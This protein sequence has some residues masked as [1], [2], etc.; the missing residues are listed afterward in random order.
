M[1]QTGVSFWIDL[2]PGVVGSVTNF[3]D[4]STTNSKTIVG[5]IAGRDYTFKITE[6]STGTVSDIVT[7]TTGF[8]RE[9]P[10]APTNVT[11]MPGNESVLIKYRAPDPYGTQNPLTGFKVEATSTSSPTTIS[12]NIPHPPVNS[13]ISYTDASGNLCYIVLNLVNSRAYTFKLYSISSAQS[14]STSNNTT[15]IPG[16][17]LAPP[18]PPAPTTITATPD[19]IVPGRVKVSWGSQTNVTSYKISCI[20][21][22][23]TASTPGIIRDANGYLS[24]DIRDINITTP[25][26]QELSFNFLK[27]D[28]FYIITLIANY[29]FPGS[30]T[31]TFSAPAQTQITTSTNGNGAPGEPSNVG[32]SLTRF[33]IN[34]NIR[35]HF[36][37]P[38]YNFNRN[39]LMCNAFAVSNPNFHQIHNYGLSQPY[40]GN[41]NGTA[42]TTTMKAIDNV[43]Y[44]G[45]TRVIDGENRFIVTDG[46]NTGKNR[47]VGF[48]QTGYTVEIELWAVL[49]ILTSRI[50]LVIFTKT[51]KVIKHQYWI[52]IPRDSEFDG[53]IDRGT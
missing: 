49:A 36:D 19:P 40:D 21:E 25:G 17:P 10:L 29:S 7:Y 5:L 30:Y 53:P 8:L 20:S 43:I 32:Y 37:I 28:T 50:C 14:T 26:P 41:T 12:Y 44:N 24:S 16:T 46:I 6:Q 38:L 22:S 18:S 1:D 15:T 48:P 52:T 42:L 51:D 33:G 31:T 2:V 13:A 9:N 3:R 45:F 27:L 23:I 34:Y 39:D 47:T 35:V 4:N 11:L